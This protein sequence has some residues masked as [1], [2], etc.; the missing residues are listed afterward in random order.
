MPQRKMVTSAWTWAT[1]T[2]NIRRNSIH[3]EEEAN[4]ILDEAFEANDQTTNET[5]MQG[6]MDVEDCNKPCNC[7]PAD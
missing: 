6:A 5:T 7:V 3:G 1:N 4:L 2:K